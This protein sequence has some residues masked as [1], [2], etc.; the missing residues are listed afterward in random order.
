VPEKKMKKRVMAKNRASRDLRQANL[1][2]WIAQP[3]WVFS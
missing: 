2:D 1:A 3:D